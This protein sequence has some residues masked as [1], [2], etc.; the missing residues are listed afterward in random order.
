MLF[1]LWVGFCCIVFF[2]LYR[3]FIFPLFGTSGDEAFIAFCSLALFFGQDG[4]NKKLP[5]FICS[6][7]C[8]AIWGFIFVLG[9]GVLMPIFGYNFVPAAMLDILVFTALAILVHTFFL[10]KTVFNNM[11]YV[12]LGVATTFSGT[13]AAGALGIAQIS[14]LLFCGMMIGTA[15]NALAPKIF[16][17]PPPV[18]QAA[19]MEKAV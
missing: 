1:G 12:F 8:G 15:S 18:E 7:I 16:G 3:G 17:P 19:S 4:N 14:L 13:V 6:G 2:G 11:A 9:V 5:S 10:A